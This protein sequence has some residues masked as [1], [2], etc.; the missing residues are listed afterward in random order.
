MTGGRAGSARK[1]SPSVV[2]RI[3]GGRDR[4]SSGMYSPGLSVVTYSALRPPRSLRTSMP[5]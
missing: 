4:L 1:R 3:R 5:R 2:R